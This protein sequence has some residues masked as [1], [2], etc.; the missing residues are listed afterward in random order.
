MQELLQELFS[1]FHGTQLKVVQVATL[2]WS[3][4]CWRVTEKSSKCEYFSRGSF[5]GAEQPPLQVKEL[6]FKDVALSISLQNFSKYQVL[7]YLTTR[8]DVT[9]IEFFTR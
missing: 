4:I 1:I 5:K 7:K 3:Q 6:L 9:L 8:I 2:A